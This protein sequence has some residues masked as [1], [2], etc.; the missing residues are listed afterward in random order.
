[1]IDNL[2]ENFS[3]FTDYYESGYMSIASKREIKS[4]INRYIIPKTKL[5]QNLIKKLKDV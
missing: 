2:E 3:T 5:L 4:Y 1:M